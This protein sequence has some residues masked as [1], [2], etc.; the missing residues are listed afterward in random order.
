MVHMMKYVEAGATMVAI[1]HMYRNSN[2]ASWLLVELPVIPGVIS[3]STQQASQTLLFTLLGKREFMAE[4]P[5]LLQ[6]D[7]DLQY[8][9]STCAVSSLQMGD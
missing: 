5:T 3:C 9:Y 4:Q 1:S 6:A 2:K 7:A 8:I